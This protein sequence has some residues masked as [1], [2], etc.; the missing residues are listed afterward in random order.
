MLYDDLT[1]LFDH[2]VIVDDKSYSN[3]NKLLHMQSTGMLDKAKFQN[4]PL[5][6]LLLKISDNFSCLYI[7]PPRSK[8]MSVKS[9]AKR[10][11][12]SDQTALQN[13]NDDLNFLNS[14]ESSNWMEIEFGE[15]LEH[16]ADEWGPTGH[17]LNEQTPPTANKTKRRY[18]DMT[19]SRLRYSQGA[20]FLP[21][22]QIVEEDEGENA[23]ENE[24]EGNA[25]NDQP[26]RTRR[27]LS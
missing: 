9:A 23:D 10:Q 25:E 11:R 14:D 1:R 22:E 24:D 13:Y 12:Q 21:S 17:I 16:S 18:S 3:S 15:A 5:R 6:D 7:A 2:A 20:N 19:S 26:L 27:R 4:R 8:P